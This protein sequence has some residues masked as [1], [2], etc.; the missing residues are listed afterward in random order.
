MTKAFNLP[1]LTRRRTIT[2]AGGLTSGL[3]ASLIKPAFADQADNDGEKNKSKKSDK[4][5]SSLPVKEI[6]H[7]MQAN[8]KMSRGVLTINMDRKHQKSSLPGNIAVTPGV[9]LNAAYYFQASGDG[10]A[11]MNAN[12]C[13]KPS[14]T[15][16]FIDAL[17]A[18][19]L[20]VQAFHQHLTD[21][22]PMYWFV[23]FRGSGDPIKLAQST[24]EALKAT[25]IGLPQHNPSHPPTPLDHEKLE[26][27]IGGKA[28]VGSNGVVT[29]SVDRAEKF[30]LGGE[31]IH[32]GLGVAATI[33]IQPLDPQGTRA[34]AIPDFALIAKEVNPVFSKMRA[35]GF[36]IGC[37]YNQETD[38]KPQLYF[39][40]Q[41]ATGN[42][43]DLAQKIRNGLN[44]TNSK[45]KYD[46]G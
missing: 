5:K 4:N 18:N 1:S 6:E 12:I 31:K 34:L 15:N 14:E 22:N 41:W 2:L 9:L 38:E 32:A 19:G 10:K 13:L 44:L 8:G 30:H 21:L 11:I 35:Q 17:I 16:K 33:A 39:S 25:S 46:K 40:H 36:I 3:T 20:T 27:I 23:H 29:V 28:Q 45:F 24:R 37:L 42:P 43:Y 7:I 26:K